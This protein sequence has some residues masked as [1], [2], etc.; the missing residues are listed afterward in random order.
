MDYKARQ[1]TQLAPTRAVSQPAWSRLKFL[2]SHTM[3]RI[4]GYQPDHGAHECAY[5]F[6]RDRHTSK[7][8]KANI[9]LHFQNNILG[10]PFIDRYHLLCVHEPRGA[11]FPLPEHTR[12][13]K[14]LTQLQR[15]LSGENLVPTHSNVTLELQNLVRALKPLDTVWIHFGGQ[16]LNEFEW[17]TADS[18]AWDLRQLLPMV[19]RNADAYCTIFIVTDFVGRNWWQLPFESRYDPVRE[20]I[21]QHRLEHHPLLPPSEKLRVFHIVPH[22]EQFGSRFYEALHLFRC[23]LTVAKLLQQTRASCFSNAAF[24]PKKVHFVFG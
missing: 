17:V 2:S 24:D 16:L 14:D 7:H 22:D 9:P 13:S 1:P 18:K 4:F 5:C 15:V 19:E 3:G 11:T 8:V 23:R 20:M 6:H 21:A 10:S 12:V